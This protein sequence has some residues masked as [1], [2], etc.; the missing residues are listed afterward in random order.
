M[1]IVLSIE[2][3]VKLIVIDWCYTLFS[4]IFLKFL[5]NLINL[6]NQIAFLDKQVMLLFNTIHMKVKSIYED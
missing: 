6:K 3:L 2:E 5:I 4:I 1:E